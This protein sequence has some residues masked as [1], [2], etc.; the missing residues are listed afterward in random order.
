MRA[1]EVG[2]IVGI[3]VL[4]LL[5]G[6]FLV[7]RR[8]YGEVSDK[9]YEIASAMY[10]VCNR[11]DATKLASIGELVKSAES[12][13]N[14]T[15]AEADFLREILQL[16]EQGDWAAATTEARRLMEDQVKYP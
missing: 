2:K 4:C 12:E 14:V 8:G 5:A 6:Y 3:L 1:S 16:A 7:G 9:T 13:S 10:S 15:T 11:Q